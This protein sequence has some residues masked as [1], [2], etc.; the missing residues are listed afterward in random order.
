MSWVTN[1]ITGSGWPLLLIVGYPL[2]A[3][4]LMELAR[5]IGD[6][7]PFTSSIL[8]PVAYVLLP[9]GT[10]W[11]ILQALAELPAENDAVRIAETLFS[12]TA[13]YILLRLVQ[14]AL[15]SVLDP[16]MRAPKLLVDILR[17]GL[18]LLWGAIVVSNLWH[19]DLGSLIAA[20]GV[21]SIVLGFALQEFLGNLLSGLGLLSAHKF[22][23][24]D[25]IVVD[26]KPTRVVE[27]DWR[28]VTL[29]DAGGRRIIVAN[30]SLAKG[31]L[32]ISARVDQPAWAEVML[33]VGVDIP[34]EE[35]CDATLEAAAGVPGLA[36]HAP[37][38]CLVTEIGMDEIKYQVLL[39]V[40]DPGVLSGPRN[41][42]LSRFW[43]I[44]QRRGIRLGNPWAAAKNPDEAARLRI[45]E[46]SGALHRDPETLP[47]LARTAK[48]HRYR[49]GEVL[50][51]Q[52][53]PAKEVLLVV[54]G[55]L[56]TYVAMEQ[57]DFRLELVGVGQL[58]AFQEMLVRGPSPMRIVAN[59]DADVLAMPSTAMVEA[60]EIDK[61]L[62]RDVGA[63][64]EARRQAL[65]ALQ[66]GLR[67]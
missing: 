24:G 18:S 3:V 37:A 31:S 35:V 5:T 10:M 48:L 62:A 41:E 33:T 67:R 42:F 1:A 50:L 47:L 17:I 43:Y 34:P 20:M 65:I 38:K 57:E 4:M 27:M 40:A 45:L 54:S 66:R 44:A 6:R 25:W 26:G 53:A 8:R 23:I 16:Q 19:V 12:L 14:A 9:T 56:A 32:I 22:G 7:S 39:P 59:T 30:S 58:I 64:T 29:I 13:L 11:L 2:L 21:G 63:L 49:R 55:T 61:I 15:D 60:F 36:G 46:T 52:G 28:T 51:A